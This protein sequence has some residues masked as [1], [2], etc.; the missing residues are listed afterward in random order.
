MVKKFRKKPVVIEAIELSKE[1]IKEVLS[2]ITCPEMLTQKQTFD[3]GLYILT[4]EGVHLAQYGD[5]VIKGVAG[6]Y[7]PCKPDIFK[8]TYEEVI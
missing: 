5:Y 1:N 7:Y 6:E 2:F 3:G 8:K 4:L